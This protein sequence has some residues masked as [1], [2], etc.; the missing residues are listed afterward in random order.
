MSDIDKDNVVD[1][2]EARKGLI[3][4]G[5][6]G[7]EDWLAKLPAGTVFVCRRKTAPK[8]QLFYDTY[9]VLSHKF[10]FATL[11]QKIPDGRTFEFPFNSLEFSRNNN[12]GA[13]LAQV[14]VPENFEKQ[15]EETPSEET[16]NDG[17]RTI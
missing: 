1:L 11:M 5:D 17:D 3:T 14:E 7:D 15:E 4:G 12:W 6:G 8:E 13:V 9:C 10:G 2:R 16:N